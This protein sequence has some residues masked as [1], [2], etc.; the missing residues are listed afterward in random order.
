MSE[1]EKNRPNKKIGLALGGGGAR[2]LAH[3]GVLKALQDAHIPIDYIAGTSMGAL[4]GGWYALN[5]SV[6]LLETLFLNIK[7]TDIFGTQKLLNQKS[8]ALFS[9]QSIIGFLK[10]G[11]KNKEFA[12]C[13]IPFAA[14]ATDF[15]NG[16]ET[17]IKNGS[18][19]EAVAASVSVPVVFK[20]VK[21]DGKLLIDGG[22]SNPVPADVVKEMGADYVIAVDVSSR[23]LNFSDEIKTHRDVYSMISDAFSVVGYQISKQILKKADVILKPPVL[24]FSWLEF[25]QTKAIIERGYFEAKH[26]LPQIEKE[27]GYKRTAPK[28]FSEKLFDFIFSND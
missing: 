5:K 19:S 27:T 8:G 25:D 23:W 16:N 22:L 9:D 2:G 26:N 17:V 14:V 18:L 21:I 28:T 3:I 15:S 24:T 4:V 7:D 12:D 10:E 20:P 13:Q 6:H 11:F 1:I